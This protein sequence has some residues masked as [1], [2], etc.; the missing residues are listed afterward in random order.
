M[1]SHGALMRVH[2]HSWSYHGAF[3]G[4]HGAFMVL[5]RCCHGAFIVLSW[6]PMWCFHGSFRA[7]S[8]WSVR[9]HGAFIVLSCWIHGFHSAFMVVHVFS[10]RFH[11]VFMM[12]RGSLPWWFHWL[13]W[14]FHVSTLTMF[15][16][17][18]STLMVLSCVPSRDRG[19]GGISSEDFPS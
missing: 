2:V 3:M 10:W 1:D 14:C 6:V 12:F 13:P 8:R 7:L 17:L 18:S 9:F 19:P 15:Y 16:G 4:S 5:P 11:G